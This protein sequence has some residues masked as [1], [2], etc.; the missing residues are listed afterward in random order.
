LNS[1]PKR[2]VYGVSWWALAAPTTPSTVPS[3]PY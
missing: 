1:P 2:T 3:K